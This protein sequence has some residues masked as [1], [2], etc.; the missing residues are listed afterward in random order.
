MDDLKPASFELVLV[1]DP[2]NYAVLADQIVAL[3]G[4]PIKKLHHIDKITHDRFGQ[5]LGGVS[6]CRRSR[7]RTFPAF[8]RI[9]EADLAIG[10]DGA[11]L[12]GDRLDRS[13]QGDTRGVSIGLACEL[14]C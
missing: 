1:H 9:G 12:I 8:R 5:I 7:Y 4:M 3:T 14:G 10:R 6:T 11:G 13:L 2:G